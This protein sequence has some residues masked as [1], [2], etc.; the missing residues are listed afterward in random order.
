[1]FAVHAVLHPNHAPH[2]VVRFFLVRSRNLSGGNVQ[3][4]KDNP[5]TTA[6]AQ[7]RSLQE[8]QMCG[9][10]NSPM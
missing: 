3:L 4:H 1:M 9:D 7:M 2:D 6:S 8:W 10:L 5:S